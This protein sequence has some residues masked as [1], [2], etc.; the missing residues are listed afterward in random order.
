LKTPI[1]V[2]TKAAMASLAEE[3]MEAQGLQVMAHAQGKMEEDVNR[4]VDLP[5]LDPKNLTS[6]L[7][8][9]CHEQWVP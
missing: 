7:E 9:A 3:A 8:E 4:E 2:T 1:K 5:S 6:T